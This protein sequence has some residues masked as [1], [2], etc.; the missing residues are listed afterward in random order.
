MEWSSTHEDFVESVGLWASR[1]H[2]LMRGQMMTRVKP[3]LMS[4]IVNFV[5]WE[6]C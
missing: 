6:S 2:R 1:Q 4:F 3:F 5:G